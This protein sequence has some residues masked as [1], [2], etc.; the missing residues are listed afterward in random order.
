MLQQY[1]RGVELLGERVPSWDVYPYTVRSIRNTPKIDLHPRVTFFV[2]ENGSGKSTLLEAIAV[3][4]GFGALGGTKD[5]QLG[6]RE[7]D[8]DKAMR[9][10]R[11]ARRERDG[12][13][14]RAETYY[15]VGHFIDERANVE[16][17]GGPV[18]ARSHG[19]AF[20]ALMNTRFRG[21]GVYLMDEPEAALS[22][23]RQLA[24]LSALDDLV[25]RRRSQ[26]VIAT[27]SPIILA[28]PD[29]KILQFSD[30][31]IERV[32]YEDTEHYQVTSAFMK[33][34]ASFL[35]HIVDSED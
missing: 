14:L 34:R 30:S 35:K 8:L 17:Y 7:H 2:G 23:T 22:P 6:E 31:G 11:G 28:Y 18:H 25:Q 21:D 12:F 24:F 16:R 19:E 26:C 20:L 13:F 33:N 29:A 10:V 15:D 5:F 3:L 32:A 1:L 4:A 27:H 9:L